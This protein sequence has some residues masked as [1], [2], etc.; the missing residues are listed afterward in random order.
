MDFLFCALCAFLWLL[1]ISLDKPSFGLQFLVD[2]IKSLLAGAFEGHIPLVSRPAI[3]APPVAGSSPWTGST[4]YLP[5]H[6]A[7]LTPR[8]HLRGPTLIGLHYRAQWRTKHTKPETLLIADLPALT[9]IRFSH[10]REST[11]SRVS[12]VSSAT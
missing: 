10:E 8:A 5:I 2:A 3:I 12:Y 9:P 6:T 11:V 1:I 4:H 7:L